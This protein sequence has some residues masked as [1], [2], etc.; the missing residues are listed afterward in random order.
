MS[1]ELNSLTGI[2]PKRYE[3]FFYVE[4]EDYLP[5]CT[6]AGEDAGADLKIHIPEDHIKSDE[7]TE[8]IVRKLLTQQQSGII[9]TIEDYISVNGKSPKRTAVD[10]WCPDMSHLVQ[11]IVRELSSKP[12]IILAPG[13][14]T[15]ISAGF[16]IAL[17]DLSDLGPFIATYKVVSRSGLSINLKV[18]I[19]N[20]PGII[21][22]GYRD[23]VKLG[24]ENTSG[25]YHF[26][27]DK[28]RL[29]QGLYEIVLDQSRV[30][31]KENI[32]S[33]AEFDKLSSERNKTGLGQ[34]GI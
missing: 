9:S 12:Y 23:W 16:K 6:H 10:N 7:H 21:D 4:D 5:V 14:T 28:A 25:N 15:V 31:R 20:A 33:K 8:R 32:V 11:P 24:V 30:V 29:A 1:I 27:T 22:R 19:A 2:D 13:T 17:P 3:P 18:K 26:F 34:S